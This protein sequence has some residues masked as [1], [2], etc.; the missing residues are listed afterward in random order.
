MFMHLHKMFSL[1]NPILLL[2]QYSIFLKQSRCTLQFA[3]FLCFSDYRSYREHNALNCCFHVCISS[4]SI[5]LKNHVAFRRSFLD[6]VPQEFP[7]TPC[8]FTMRHYSVDIGVQDLSSFLI[9]VNYQFRQGL[10]PSWR[11][12]KGI[13]GSALLNYP[14]VVLSG[15]F[16]RRLQYTLFYCIV[17][18]SVVLLY[19]VFRQPFSVIL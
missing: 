13:M 2:Y 12:S 16:S 3:M 7:T 14:L 17:Y 15:R 4:M 10:T 9:L 8:I 19:F 11:G 18:L 5:S 1:G 6:L